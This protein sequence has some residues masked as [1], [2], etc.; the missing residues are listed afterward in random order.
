MK[1]AAPLLFSAILLFT[2]CDSFGTEEEEE[3]PEP[4]EAEILLVD[5]ND[6][7]TRTA[8]GGYWDPDASGPD[9]YIAIKD[10]LTGNYLYTA[11]SYVNDAASTAQ[12]TYAPDL[13]LQN[14]SRMVVIEM[15]DRDS[16]DDDKMCESTEFTGSDLVEGEIGIGSET[17]VGAF[18]DFT[19]RYEGTE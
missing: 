6:F 15:W 10:P 11:D 9:I 7:P 5:V 1:Y 2:G 13:L 14:L 3:P 16:D 4:K 17:F 12:P 8:G 19:V 18:C